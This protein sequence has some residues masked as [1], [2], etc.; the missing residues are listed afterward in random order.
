LAKR[1]P[2]AAEPSRCPWASWTGDD[3][4]WVLVNAFP[5]CDA[6]G[7]LRQV[8]VTFIAR[9]ARKQ[10]EAEARHLN[11]TLEQRVQ[12]RSHCPP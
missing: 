1:R 3:R 10:A 2:L 12:E 8:E 5:Q 7:Q 9:T 11:Q 4:V 6:A